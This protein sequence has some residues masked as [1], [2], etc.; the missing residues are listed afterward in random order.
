VRGKIAKEL[1]KYGTKKN[2]ERHWN[3][4]SGFQLRIPDIVLLQRT[5]PLWNRWRPRE[6]THKTIDGEKHGK[7]ILTD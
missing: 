1:E 3:D 4:C 7:N 2:Q 6:F 5:V